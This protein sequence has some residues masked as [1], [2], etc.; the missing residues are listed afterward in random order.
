MLYVFRSK[1][2]VRLRVKKLNYHGI[3]NEQAASD[4]VSVDALQPSQQ[5]FSHVRTLN[6]CLPGL[7]KYWK[8]R[9]KCPAQEHNTVPPVSDSN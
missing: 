8:Q 9:I 3:C 2:K 6:C 1:K 5:F 7:N 4:F